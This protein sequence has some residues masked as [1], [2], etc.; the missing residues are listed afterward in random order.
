MPPHYEFM[1]KF[2]D[3]IKNNLYA[4]KRLNGEFDWIDL[5]NAAAVA[6][7]VGGSDRRSQSSDGKFQFGDLTSLAGTID[8][9]RGE[10]R[11]NLENTLTGEIDNILGTTGSENPLE[12]THGNGGPESKPEGSGNAGSNPEGGE[13]SPEIKDET[14]TNIEQNISYMDWAD[15]KITEQREREDSAY[16]RAVADMRKAGI[17]PN[18]MNVQPAAS[19]AGNTSGMEGIENMLEELDILLDKETTMEEGTKDR[20][21][22]IVGT[23]LMALL[24]KKV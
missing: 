1:G 15:Q 4:G 10:D 3:W 17:N 19:N 18:L 11:K 20:I 21:N 22:S 14:D 23:V 16:Q 2:K 12:N 6:N 5:L 9:I 24:F 13:T 7:A 8:A